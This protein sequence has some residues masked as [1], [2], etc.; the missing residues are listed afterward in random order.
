[1]RSRDPEHAALDFAGGLLSMV[2]LAVL[3]Y[4]VIG[5]PNNGWLTP[6]TLASFA[7]AAVLGLGFV[8]WE[9]RAPTPM[10]DLAFFRDRRFTIG[11]ATISVSFFALFAVYFLLTQYLQ[12]VRGYAPLAAG[13]HTIPAGVTQMIAAPASA[14]LVERYGAR[15][16]VSL[17]VA[18]VG[19]G[20]LLLAG[21]GLHS[22][23][24][25]LVL[26][27]SVLG[28]GLGLATPPATAVIISS[29]PLRKAGVGSA[30]ND[31]TREL[32]GAVGIAVLGS[33]T[34]S[35]Y[36]GQLGHVLAGLRLPPADVAAA[37]H[38]VGGAVQA[39]SRMHGR[40]ASELLVAART[41]FANGMHIALVVGGL[42]ALAGAA[43]IHRALPRH[44][45]RD[46]HEERAREA[47]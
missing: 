23:T 22:P 8:A 7:V 42:L 29:L 40:A 18:G 15:A 24:W 31:T 36:R 39:A 20:A 30:V 16:I 25:L 43:A 10:L 45:L 27:L 33:I 26:G 38:G 2:A 19:V 9:R 37:H 28:C 4:G 34:A 1:M 13:V 47:A 35:R 32:G 12:V 44:A 21:L 14:R 6:V 41:A 3:L 17:G 11:C 5:A 46:L